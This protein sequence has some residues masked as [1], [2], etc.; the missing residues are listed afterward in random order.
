[1]GYLGATVCVDGGD[2]AD[3]EGGSGEDACEVG[4]VGL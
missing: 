1:M 3:V 4:G 2:D